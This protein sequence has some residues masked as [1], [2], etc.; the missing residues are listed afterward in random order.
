M[1]ITTL[2]YFP[3][4]EE[5]A[6]RLAEALGCVAVRMGL[7]HF[8]DGESLVRLPARLNGD[9][10]IYVSLDHP[11][12]KLVPLGFAAATAR[13]LGASTVNLVAPYLCY[14]RQDMAF[15]PGEAVSQRIV[16]HWLDQWFDTVFTVDAHLHRVHSIRDVV[17]CG[18][19]ISAAP[20][21]AEFL[22]QRGGQP[23]L[24]GPDEESLQWV[25]EIGTLAGLDFGVATKKRYGD[26]DVEIALPDM[27]FRDREVI[28][29]DDVLSSGFTVAGTATQVVDSGASRVQCMVTH[30]LFAPGAEKL[31]ED[32]GV[33]R[34]ISTDTIIHH[35]N[36]I[37]MAS[38]L[39][40]ALREHVPASGQ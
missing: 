2:I 8:P 20:L 13:D 14:M 33:E 30:A 3:D 27:D 11:D 7:H 23:I 4:F 35:S 1:E 40:L 39:A 6:V 17:P 24:L 12:S 9:V 22:R 5:P 10:I 34:V 19:N 37:Y 28:I 38:G 21:M 16:G 26:R 18:V 31:L 25:Q 15:N 36:S 29:V 32:S